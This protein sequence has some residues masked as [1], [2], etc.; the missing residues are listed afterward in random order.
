MTV[1]SKS[2][3]NVVDGRVFH[4][5]PRGAT[6]KGKVWDS[7][8]GD[9]IDDDGSGNHIVVV[10]KQGKNPQKT[11]LTKSS[12]TAMT[13][14]SK[15]KTNV[16]D[17]R[18]WTLSPVSASSSAIRHWWY[19]DPFTFKSYLTTHYLRSPPIILYPTAQSFAVSEISARSLP[20]SSSFTN[21]C[22]SSSSS[23][24]FLEHGFLFAAPS[25][26]SPFHL[27]CR[28][29][30]YLSPHGIFPLSKCRFSFNYLSSSSSAANCAF[31]SS[32]RSCLMLSSR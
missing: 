24:F 29:G 19:V 2:K 14:S 12:M 30:V 20:F 7:V 23:V 9:W 1:S 25:F 6:P 26:F 5:R 4:K 28:L 10:H 11:S 15:S 21:P 17:G 27:P 18:V 8:L 22:P 31:F 16:V 32:L 13:V 3:T